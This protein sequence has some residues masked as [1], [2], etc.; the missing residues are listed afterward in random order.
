MRSTSFQK[1]TGLIKTSDLINRDFNRLQNWKPQRI[2]I[3]A[4]LVTEDC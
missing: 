4:Y 2:A 3:L 1:R